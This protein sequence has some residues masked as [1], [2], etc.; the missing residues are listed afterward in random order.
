MANPF[1]QFDATAAPAAGNPFDQFDAKAK[2][3]TAKP[4][5]DFSASNPATWA[6]AGL[7]SAGMGL[8]TKNP[9]MT[10]PPQLSQDVAAAH[11]GLGWMDYPLSAAAYAVGP[12]FSRGM[13]RDRTAEPPGA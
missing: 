4:G 13:A 2:T 9:F 11:E 3:A 8:G 6:L 5:P 10:M 7:D 12:P 1:D